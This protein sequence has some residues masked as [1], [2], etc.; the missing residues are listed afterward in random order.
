MPSYMVHLKSREELDLLKASTNPRGIKVSLRYVKDYLQGLLGGTKRRV[1]AE[2]Y[3]STIDAQNSSAFVLM[4]SGSGT[5]GPTV[6]GTAATVTWATSDTNTGTL[7]AAAV[8]AATA[9]NGIALAR[10]NVATVACSSV[11]AGDVISILGYKFTAYNGTT[12]DLFQFDMSSTDTADAAALATKINAAPGI[13]A[14]VCADAASG[15]VYIGLKPNIS[16]GTETCWTGATTMT[17]TNGSFAASATCMVMG[18]LPGIMG[19][20]ISIS[21]S[22]TGCTV[23]GSRTKLAAGLGFSGIVAGTGYS[24]GV[25]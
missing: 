23:A 15:T 1:Q 19:N 20:A 17:V 10:N 11:A 8:N 22:G 21:A 9:I 14:L 18:L 24:Q 7:I 4:S 6:N 13:S 2:V 16:I 25:M 5:V 3:P 12:T